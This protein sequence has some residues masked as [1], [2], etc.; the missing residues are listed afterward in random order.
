MLLI[1]EYDPAESFRIPCAIARIIRSPHSL[2]LRQAPVRLHPGVH[3]A[4]SGPRP[5]GVGP[6]RRATADALPCRL[7]EHF[8]Y[9]ARPFLGDPAHP[10]YTPDASRLGRSPRSRPIDLFRPNRE[11]SS[12]YARKASDVRMRTQG[13]LRPSPGRHTPMTVLDQA[14]A[15]PCIPGGDVHGRHFVQKQELRQLLRVGTN[16]LVLEAEDPSKVAEALIADKRPIRFNTP[17]VS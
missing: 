3:G 16:M 7:G 1:A 10:V 15:C 11:G 13:V 17:Q 8:P 2:R 6:D 5:L 12:T 4:R 9:G 14:A